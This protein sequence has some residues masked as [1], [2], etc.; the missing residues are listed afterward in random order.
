MEQQYDYTQAQ[1]LLSPPDVR[2]Y[3]GVATVSA[4]ALPD[5]FELKICPIKS[6][7]SVGSCVAHAICSCVEY[8]NE[9]EADKFEKMSTGYIYG[10]RTT[11]SWKGVGMYV[12]GALSA[13][14]HCG[15]TKASD[16][17]VNVEVPD[18]I[19]KFEEAR[20]TYANQAYENRITKYYRLYNKDAMKAS[21]YQGNP[22]VFVLVFRED[23]KIE[24][25]VWIVN[26]KSKK[27]GGSHCMY[28]YGW[29]KTGWKVANSW[30]N[31][32]GTKG[33]IILPYETKISEAWG[34]EDTY[35]SEK[36]DAYIEMLKQQLQ[37]LRV[38]YNSLR[39]IHGDNP[40][41]EGQKLIADVEKRMEA[42]DLEIQKEQK[43]LVKI[44]TPFTKVAGPV[45]D[46]MNA[47]ALMLWNLFG[48]G[49]K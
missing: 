34:L 3:K 25:G 48:G 8:F 33:T 49:K 38:E 15:T 45:I 19:T 6:Q 9:K 35:D 23:M 18:A 7:G 28:I 4:D 40:N 26:E 24:N 21:L 27:T 29:N 5:E 30:G 36:S 20:K 31:K 1:A 42:I 32:W 47:I 17:D 46:V 11:Q 37:K 14:R 44:K 2:D 10:N 43:K 39:M 13:V 22:V 12:N 41:A 16:W